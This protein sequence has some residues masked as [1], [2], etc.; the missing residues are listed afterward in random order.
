MIAVRFLWNTLMII[1]LLIALL[2]VII[3]GLWVLRIAVF[4][5]LEIDYVEEAKK[6]LRREK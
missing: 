5:W 2:I 3:G 1:T 6:Y 4:W